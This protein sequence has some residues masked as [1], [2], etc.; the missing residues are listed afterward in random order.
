MTFKYKDGIIS[1]V[2]KSSGASSTTAERSN[3]NKKLVLKIKNTKSGGGGG[4]TPPTTPPVTP[5]PITMKIAGRVYLDQPDNNKSNTADGM[6]G[7]SD[8]L[9]SG[10]EVALYDSNDKLAGLAEKTSGEVDSSIRTNPTLTDVDG[11]YEF[12]G[13]NAMGKYYVV[14]TYN[15]QTYTN[16]TYLEGSGYTTINQVVSAKKYNTEIW[17]VTS[18]A[19]EGISNRQTYNNTFS[20]IASPPASYESSNNLG[21]LTTSSDNKY[22]N[23]AYQDAKMTD[24]YTEIAK[25]VQTYINTYKKYPTDFKTRDIC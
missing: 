5:I 17:E 18:K 22:Y 25:A 16:V 15:G 11:Y 23:I 2:E 1:N 4:T 7:T 12:K 6:L 24:L 19:S 10:V 13:V 9:L 8:I 20:E 3:N 14:F 21:Y